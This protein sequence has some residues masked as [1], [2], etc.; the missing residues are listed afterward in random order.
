MSKPPRIWVSNATP[1]KGEVVRVRAQMEHVMESGLRTDPA[2]GKV[3]PRNIVNRF[4]ARLGSAL[5]FTWEP[6]ISIAQNPYIEFTFLARESGEL[7]MLWKDEQGQ[8][9]NAQKAITVS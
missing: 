4:E 1:K 8:T 2:S 7:N 9:L 3:R 5:L 6:G